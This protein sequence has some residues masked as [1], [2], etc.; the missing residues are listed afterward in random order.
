MLSQNADKA[1]TTRGSDSS[2]MTV[3]VTR[4][5]WLFID[6]QRHQVGTEWGEGGREGGAESSLEAVAH[7]I[8]VPLVVSLRRD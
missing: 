4:P 5:G 8:D 3:Q 1:M 2:Q 6:Q 7:P